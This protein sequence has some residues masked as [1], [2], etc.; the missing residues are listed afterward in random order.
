[1]LQDCDEISLNLLTTG[2]AVDL[3]LRAGRV[4]DEGAAA[5]LAAAKIAELLGR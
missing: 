5:Q 2:E 3:L 4:E 1:M